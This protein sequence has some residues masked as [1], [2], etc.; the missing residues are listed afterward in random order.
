MS[1][2]FNPPPGWPPQPEGWQ[3]PPGWAPDPSWPPAPTGWQF[4]VPAEAPPTPTSPTTAAPFPPYQADPGSPPPP[5]GQFPPAGPPGHPYGGGQPPFAGAPGGYPQPGY[6]GYP[7]PG[8]PST[9]PWYQRGGVIALGAGALVLLTALV[10]VGTFIV[11]RPDD[12][13]SGPVAAASDPSPSASE[14]P[15]PGPSEGPEA[16]ESPDSG[17]LRGGAGERFEGEGSRQISFDLV[18]GSYYT[19]SLTHR[20]GDWFELWSTEGDEDASS[21][22]WG[23]GDYE[24]TFGLNL[25]YDEDPDGIRIETDG[26]WTI[27]VHELSESPTWPDLYEGTGAQVLALEPG[28]SVI[29]DV[30]HSGSSNFIVWAYM[31]DGYPSLLFNEIGAYQGNATIPEQTFALTIVADG[32][33]SIV[34]N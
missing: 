3:P 22:T 10:G 32:D 11:L 29:V 21:L 19:V 23:I 34:P 30:T 18:S 24:G 1:W 6:P 20:G 13:D 5:A 27:E 9:K 4:W 25:F 16:S 7:Q 15:S 2:R 31:E 26:A 14:T 28:R 33:W 17:E 12:A 8:Y